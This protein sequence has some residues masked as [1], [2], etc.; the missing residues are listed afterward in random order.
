MD[1]LGKHV[2]TRMGVSGE[3]IRSIQNSAITKFKAELER[4]GIKVEDLIDVKQER[5][6]TNV[7]K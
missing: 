6:L 3:T 5:K 1:D 4:R 7:R 2:D